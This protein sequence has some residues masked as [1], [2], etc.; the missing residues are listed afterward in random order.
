[1]TERAN[2]VKNLD[3]FFLWSSKKLLKVF[4]QWT[5]CYESI[6]EE[7]LCIDKH[8]CMYVYVDVFVCVISMD[9]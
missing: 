2:V 5:G 1:M 8:L 4:K 3:F 6:P 7:S 9:R